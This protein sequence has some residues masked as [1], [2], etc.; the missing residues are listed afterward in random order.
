MLA[1]IKAQIE[2]N[3]ISSTD[4]PLFLP[5]ALLAIKRKIIGEQRD[6]LWRHLTDA[7]MQTGQTGAPMFRHYAQSGEDDDINEITKQVIGVIQL[8]TAA[9][10]H[11][12][13]LLTVLEAVQKSI[14]II[15]ETSGQ[16]DI[17]QRV[18]EMLTERLEFIEQKTKMLIFDLQYFEKRA[19]AQLTA[20][21][22]PLM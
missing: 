7:E 18:G 14:Q 10:Q 2:G 19:Q 16:R 21:D 22:V 8:S 1:A 17:V 12:K 13:T 3:P 4:H 9:E 20:D 11:A 6:M 15:G 5:V